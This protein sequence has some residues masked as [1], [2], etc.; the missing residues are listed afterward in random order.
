MPF[1]PVSPASFRQFKDDFSKSS[2]QPVSTSIS[3]SDKYAAVARTIEDVVRDVEWTC[4]SDTSSA[5]SFLDDHRDPIP[6]SQP[7][8]SASHSI[9]ASLYLFAAAPHVAEGL[10]AFDSSDAFPLIFS[11]E[12]T[13]IAL[14]S[15]SNLRHR[16]SNLST[17]MSKGQE[18]QGSGVFRGALGALQKRDISFKWIDTEP[19]CGFQQNC[20]AV[21]K[22]FAKWLA[23]VS[24]TIRLISLKY[25]FI[26]ERVASSTS[27]LQG[28]HEHGHSIYDSPQEQLRDARAKTV[29]EWVEVEVGVMR[30]SLQSKHVREPLSFNRCFQAQ[31]GITSSEPTTQSSHPVRAV[32]ERCVFG[33]LR[34]VLRGFLPNASD[35]KL[36][37]L[38]A[39]EEEASLLRPSNKTMPYTSSDHLLWASL[40]AGLMAKLALTETSLTAD[41]AMMENGRNIFS[42]SV[43]V[44]PITMSSANIRKIKIGRCRSLSHYG[45]AS[46]IGAA[47]NKD[48][49][50]WC[51]ASNIAPLNVKP[52]RAIFQRLLHIPSE[53]EMEEERIKRS[54]RV[55]SVVAG[56]KEFA[57]ISSRE[58][59][60]NL[61]H[62]QWNTMRRSRKG[63]SVDKIIA[64]I[65]QK[66]TTD[67]K[68]VCQEGCPTNANDIE[69]IARQAREAVA[70]SLRNEHV[71]MTTCCKIQ[72][73][74]APEAAGI[75]GRMEAPMNVLNPDSCDV[76]AHDNGVQSNDPAAWSIFKPRSN[77]FVSSDHAPRST[78][79]A[80]SD[81][82]LSPVAAGESPNWPTLQPLH[83]STDADPC[84]LGPNP[85]EVTNTHT[86]PC[87][88]A[89]HIV[90]KLGPIEADSIPSSSVR[91]KGP[92]CEPATSDIHGSHQST[93]V[94]EVTNSFS[95]EIDGSAMLQKATIRLDQSVSEL[96][97]ARSDNVRHRVAVCLGHISSL[98]E[99]IA[100]MDYWRCIQNSFSSFIKKQSV[101]SSALR[102][103]YKCSRISKHVPTATPN[104]KFWAVIIDALVQ[105]VWHIAEG[106][107]RYQTGTSRIGPRRRKNLTDRAISILSCVQLAG[108]TLSGT[109]GHMFYREVI[110]NFFQNVIV[111]FLDGNHPKSFIDAVKALFIEYDVDHSSFCVPPGCELASGSN[112]DHE[113][114]E[115][116][117]LKAGDKI[118]SHEHSLDNRSECG[119]RHLKKR[120]N[121][122]IKAMDSETPT[123]RRCERKPDIKEM[124][125]LSR[126]KKIAVEQRRSHF[127]RRILNVERARHLQKPLSLMRDKYGK[128]RDYPEQKRFLLC[129]SKKPRPSQCNSNLAQHSRDTFALENDNSE[130]EN[131]GPRTSTD[132]FT[133]LTTGDDVVVPATP[134]H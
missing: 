75:A 51:N 119:S 7:S 70:S 105:V 130:S 118:R 25:F 111:K 103:A 89:P 100:D 80:G 104:P 22:S 96:T 11:S 31:L 121:K 124:I 60:S 53:G 65:R 27:L 123:K 101:V 133:T 28:L 94:V 36:D 48:G 37:K 109:D 38:S 132:T 95:G 46:D 85:T 2:S 23:S 18:M 82:S 74:H 117:V 115:P 20:S 29:T 98:V 107:N 57:V 13:A 92:S 6:S 63:L 91:E 32:P 43:L 8:C 47:A 77:S 35:E 102:N 125:A 88:K 52:S 12:R 71:N 45:K 114:V 108:E 44:R 84:S 112:S 81:P 58:C 61:F 40:F 67:C 73:S 78:R 50:S 68:A 93:P 39:F 1:L 26:D 116:C 42:H 129:I 9:S 14:T 56:L 62:R 110:T 134:S 69:Q 16:L 33:L 76:H 5:D 120:S 3:F 126:D 127:S 4:I 87:L 55:Q 99:I 17:T 54:D 66:E 113:E 122:S 131:V 128:Q 79:A 41:I 19:F 34:M 97:S 64:A 24:A 72:S 83:P 86:M 30:Q 90:D 49:G 15:G 21:S 10:L 59:E 106:A